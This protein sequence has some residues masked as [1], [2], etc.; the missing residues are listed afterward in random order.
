M[1]R[2]VIMYQTLKIVQMCPGGNKILKNVVVSIPCE[3]L[4]PK[5]DISN[6]LTGFT[7][8]ETKQNYL[9]LEHISCRNYG[10]YQVNYIKLYRFAGIKS[11][12]KVIRR[13]TII[14]GVIRD[15]NLANSIRGFV[16][17]VSIINKIP[18]FH[19][20]KWCGI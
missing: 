4:F 9:H 12:Y 8:N 5:T 3:Y 17:E 16:L 2:I 19:R 10:I 15:A 6:V 14:I 20:T 13:N 7:Y 18:R 1:G 11:L